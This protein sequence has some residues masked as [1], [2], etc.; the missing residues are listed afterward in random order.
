MTRRHLVLARV[1]GSPTEF[2]AATVTADSVLRDPIRRSSLTHMVTTLL[3]IAGADK[4]DVT[5][6]TR[7]ADAA[8]PPLESP[9]GLLEYAPRASVYVL[10]PEGQGADYWVTLWRTPTGTLTTAGRS[11]RVVSRLAVTGLRRLIDGEGGVDDLRRRTHVEREFLLRHDWAASDIVPDAF[12]APT[13]P[14]ALPGVAERWAAHR[15]AARHR[16]RSRG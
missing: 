9:A 16:P 5:L 2:S 12:P 14:A 8:L 6:T 15:E 11:S 7:D 1:P 4:C 13:P 10:C 3:D